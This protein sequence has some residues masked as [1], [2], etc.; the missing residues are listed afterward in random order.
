[1]T[2]AYVSG[3]KEDLRLSEP[4]FL[5]M[6]LL[7]LSNLLLSCLEGNELHWFTTY[8][9]IGI[10]IGGPFFTMALTVFHP[11]Y[12]LPACTLCWSFF[13]LFMYKAES[14]KTIYILR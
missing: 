5:N 13:V 4:L 7:Q 8:F 12:W 3:M 14:A 6:V 1:M 9:N 10:I 2:N 11:R